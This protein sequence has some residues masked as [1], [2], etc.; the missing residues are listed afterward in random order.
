MS[1]IQ[2]IRN[3]IYN[4]VKEVSL[5]DKLTYTR[6]EVMKLLFDTGL[7]VDNLINAE[8]REKRKAERT[9]IVSAPSTPGMSPAKAQARKQ[10]TEAIVSEMAK[11]RHD[12]P[13][14]RTYNRMY[15]YHCMTVPK[16]GDGDYEHSCDIGMPLD[17]CTMTCP[18]ATNARASLKPH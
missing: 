11:A 17:N 5:K 4:R 18:Y 12:E 15:R 13:I 3:Y 7:Q 16:T 1:N 6:E 8:V 10:R 14:V 9:V 2:N